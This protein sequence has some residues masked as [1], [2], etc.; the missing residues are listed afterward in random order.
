MCGE[1]G[2]SSG[3]WWSILQVDGGLHAIS[4]PAHAPMCLRATELCFHTTEVATSYIDEPVRI[5]NTLHLLSV[6]RPS[7]RLHEGGRVGTDLKG[8]S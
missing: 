3:L 1:R 8:R 5:E 7:R 2:V 6:P 4:S